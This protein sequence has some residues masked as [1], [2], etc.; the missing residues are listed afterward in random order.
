M[1][2]DSLQ[3][4]VEELE[5]L[6]RL[7]NETRDEAMHRQTALTRAVADCVQGMHL[8]AIDRVVQCWAELLATGLTRADVVKNGAGWYFDHPYG[9]DMP[10]E[11]FRASI[12]ARLRQLAMS[13]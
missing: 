8:D 6:E 11:R 1:T 12:C 3:A 7:R 13:R 5:R 2:R 10:P 9:G 4:L